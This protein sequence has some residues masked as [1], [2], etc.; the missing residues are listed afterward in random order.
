MER[1]TVTDFY[2]VH[3]LGMV[4][5][6]IKDKKKRFFEISTGKNYSILYVDNLC[7]IGK[8]EYI[9]H[10]KLIGFDH[11]PLVVPSNYPS[12]FGS[13]IKLKIDVSRNTESNIIEIY[14]NH[15]LDI[16]DYKYCFEKEELTPIPE[17]PGN[18]FTVTEVDYQQAMDV[19]NPGIPEGI[20]KED[21]GAMDE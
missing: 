4:L 20:K 6:N 16:H 10:G 1:Y 3:S 13:L 8:E 11:T 21:G 18:S 9:A 17:F 15:I 5:E 14:A 2:Q 7:D 12:Y 19:S